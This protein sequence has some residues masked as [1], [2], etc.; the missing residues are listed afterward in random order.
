MAHHSRSILK[1]AHLFLDAVNRYQ[2]E[3]PY[4]APMLYTGS[5]FMTLAPDLAGKGH[6]PPAL[7]EQC[8]LDDIVQMMCADA[9]IYLPQD[10]LLKV[11][12]ASMAHSLEVRA[13]FLDR[14]VVELAFSLPGSWHR[15]RFA[16]KHMLKETFGQYLPAS[17]W[18]RRKQG[19]GVPLHNWFRG[20][21]GSEL[22][23]MLN[24]DTRP[25]VPGQVQTL[26]EDHRSKKR[27]NSYRLWSIYVYLLFLQRRKQSAKGID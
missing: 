10:I 22:S 2:D 4:T 20:E 12:R 11:D 3:T 14:E 23:D 25:I 8:E 5:E 24:G 18:K 13:P 26:L 1:K 6:A 19:F 21:L 15:R 7:P 9:M 27:D 17:I 16:G